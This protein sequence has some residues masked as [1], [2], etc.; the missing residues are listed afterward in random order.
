MR[1]Y[2]IPKIKKINLN[3]EML[4][5]IS[6]VLIFLSMVFIG[7][8][9]ISLDI[10]GFTVRF[11]QLILVLESFILFL[12]GKYKIIITIPMIAVVASH[13]LSTIFTFDLRASLAYD[14]WLIYNFLFVLYVFYSYAKSTK[15]EK[16]IDLIL[17]SFIIQS[18]Y[19]YI[20]FIVGS[21][22]YN[23][24]FFSMQ[25]YMGIYRPSIWF[26]EPSY[27]ATYFSVYFA[28]SIYLLI[29]FKTRKY[30][31]NSINALLSLILIT[32]TTGYL[33][34][35]F[36]I[37]LMLILN[38]KTLLNINKK[39]LL[40]VLVG[41]IIILVIVLNMN[42]GFIDVFLGRIFR[43]GLVNSSGERIGNWMNTF[44]IFIQYPILGI[45]P[46]AY[47]RYTGSGTPPTNVSLELLANLGV[48]GFGAFY[49][50]IISILKK[51]YKKISE[52]SIYNKAIVIAIIVFMVTLQAN[53]NYMRLYL[54]M[55]LGICIGFTRKKD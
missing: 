43:D 42:I 4:E 23:D 26:Y 3:N 32:S 50:F 39:I 9:R 20:Q 12:Q 1:E 33:A 31:A 8:D 10:G 55:L 49:Y 27:V 41:I 7:S 37:F 40:G 52:T 54:W 35:G 47:M 45:G 29:N 28:L 2:T 17:F 6:L 34:I 36:T 38:I 25:H 16:V 30:I 24:P 46:N 11:V 15:K 5:K 18:I 51:C 21:L 48:T 22:G 13:I 53:Q 14:F 44:N 19:I